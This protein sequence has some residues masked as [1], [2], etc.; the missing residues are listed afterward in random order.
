MEKKWFLFPAI[1]LAFAGVTGYAYTSYAEDTVQPASVAK[2]ATEEAQGRER[3]FGP[4]FSDNDRTK[5]DEA[6]ASGNYET[7]KTV[8]EEREPPRMTEVITKENFA[9]FAE[10]HTLRREGKVEEA[11]ALRDELGLPERGK[12]HGAKMGGEGR[13]LG[14]NGESC[15][16]QQ[17]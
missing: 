6:M 5:L 8:M 16:C 9:K 15:P 17:E 4:R 7:W 14:G 3:G 11:D 2:A 1:A 12:G 13:R 10:M